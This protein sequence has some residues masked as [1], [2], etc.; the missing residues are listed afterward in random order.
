VQD[1]CVTNICQPDT[2]PRPEC[3]SNGDCIGV[4]VTQDV[5]VDAVCRSVCASDTDCCTGSSGSVCQMGY[6]VTSNEV[7][8]QCHINSDCSAGQSCIN[9]ACQ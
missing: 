3:L 1:L 8:P 4:H 7:S 5:C 2:G 9:A 6:C